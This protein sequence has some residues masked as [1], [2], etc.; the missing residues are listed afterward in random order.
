[1]EKEHKEN[2]QKE[3]KILLD[4]QVEESGEKIDLSAKNTD[5]KNKNERLKTEIRK[6]EETIKGLQPSYAYQLAEKFGIIKLKNTMVSIAVII[7]VIATIY[8]LSLVLKYI[9]KPA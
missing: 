8:A 5:L 6:L 4:K 3:L 1:M 2:A 7:G 9:A